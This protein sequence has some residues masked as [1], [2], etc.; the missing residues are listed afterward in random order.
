MSNGSPSAVRNPNFSLF[1]IYAGIREHPVD[2]STMPASLLRAGL[3]ICGYLPACLPTYL[4]H[5]FSPVFTTKMRTHVSDLACEAGSAL[6]ARHGTARPDCAVQVYSAVSTS[7]RGKGVPRRSYTHAT[8][9]RRSMAAKK[10][11]EDPYRKSRY[12]A[13]K[14]RSP[15]R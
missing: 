8:R 2:P 15:A 9:R 13:T 11:N 4:V 10:K 12:Y 3:R 14:P 1:A 7:G 5:R 6:P